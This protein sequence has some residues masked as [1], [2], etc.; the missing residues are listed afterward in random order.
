M[1]TSYKN[2]FQKFSNLLAEPELIKH[3]RHKGSNTFCRNRKMPLKD[4]LLCCLSKKGLTTVFELRN[5]FKEKEEKTMPLSVQ[6]YL[7][8]RK[9]LN[10]E[11]F[12]YL[13][14]EYL[15]DFYHSEEPKLWN[16]Y[17]L[18][19]ID[20][21]KAEV[22]NSKEN[23]ERF[24]NSGNQHSEQGQVRALVSGVYDIL[25][26]FYLDIEIEHISVSET[27]L[28]KRN[29]E[30]LK[31]FHLKQPILLIFDRGYPSIEFIDFLETEGIRYLFRLSSNDYIAERKRMD[32][33]D[34]EI[35]LEHT[36]SRLKKIQKKHPERYEQLKKKSGTTVRISSSELPS[37]NE[38]LLM[39]NISTDIAAKELADLYY[40][41]WEIEKKYHTLKNKMKLESITGKASIYVYQDFWAQILV[42]NMIQDIRKSA[43]EEVAETGKQNGSK[44]T[45]HTNEN[46]AI[47]LFKESMIKILLEPEPQKC[48][49]KLGNLQSEME[50]YVLPIRELPSKERK[51]N[52]SNKYCN[53]QKHSF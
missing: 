3:A 25:N 4:M 24:G 41:R 32:S 53:N 19:A 34:E 8:Q 30:N 44:Y 6:G 35:I 43:N 28:A 18:L 46:V 15:F 2:R 49:K 45:M 50:R 21:S 29:L 17:L 14:R 51:K 12:S 27:E 9:R 42:Y 31:Q 22:P 38:L 26:Q 40:H 23:R 20:G 39:T 36:Y 48:I 52:L 37:G 7:Q 1:S 47:G 16:G 11:V 5:Y 10:P 13:N 33:P